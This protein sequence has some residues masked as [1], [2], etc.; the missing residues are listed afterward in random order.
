MSF[1]VATVRGVCKGALFKHN[2]PRSAVCCL[3]FLVGLPDERWYSLG[4][5][6]MRSRYRN[7]VLVPL[8]RWE[9]FKQYKKYRLIIIIRKYYYDYLLNDCQQIAMKQPRNICQHEPLDWKLRRWMPRL[10]FPLPATAAEAHSVIYASENFQDGVALGS[11]GS[12]WGG[13]Q[14]QFYISF[15]GHIPWKRKG[16]EAKKGRIWMICRLVVLGIKIVLLWLWPGA[17]IYLCY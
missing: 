5:S 8:K 12:S 17:C 2:S 7:V 13:K 11:I 15:L 16:Q 14:C 9:I 3:A 6:N 10:P 4:R 1:L